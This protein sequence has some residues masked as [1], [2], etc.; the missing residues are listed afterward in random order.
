[1]RPMLVYREEVIV[2]ALGLVLLCIA[3]LGLLLGVVIPSASLVLGLGISI[4]NN[5]AQS[6]KVLFF[7]AHPWI[8]LLVGI[9]LLAACGWG[10]F[11]FARG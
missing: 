10:V 8:P 11:R 6:G 1:M 9:L 4:P 2:K 7:Y 5:W 3:S